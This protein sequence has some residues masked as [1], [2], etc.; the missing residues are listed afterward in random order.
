[1]DRNGED[2]GMLVQLA[3]SAHLTCCSIGMAN[4]PLTCLQAMDPPHMFKCLDEEERRILRAA[5]EQFLMGA[6]SSASEH[7]RGQAGLRPKAPEKLREAWLELFQRRRREQ[8]DG[9]LLLTDETAKAR[10]F[11]RWVDEWLKENLRADQL[12]R[13]RARQTSIFCAYMKR[14][15]GGKYFVMALLETGLN[16]SPP[17]DPVGATEHVGQQFC[18]W[19]KA[20]LEARMRQAW[21][22]RAQEAHGRL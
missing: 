19:L 2:W 13:A 21:C 18:A 5:T 10:I 7:G 14:V 1:M 20:L 12:T 17:S 9:T 11:T 4:K 15:Y 22:Y 8:P 6:G 3:E 16:W